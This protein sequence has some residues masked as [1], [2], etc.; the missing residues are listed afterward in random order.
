MISLDGISSA[1]LALD[2]AGIKIS[3]YYSS[4]IDKSALAIQ[5]Y[6]YSGNS[7]FTRLEM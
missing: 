7:N 3:N 2:K 4:E 5:N 1:K 6:H